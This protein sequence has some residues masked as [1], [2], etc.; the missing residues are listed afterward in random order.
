MPLNPPKQSTP[1]PIRIAVSFIS[2][3]PLQRTS[4]ATVPSHMHS[5]SPLRPA[6][7]F[8]D[9]HPARHPLGNDGSSSGG[10]DVCVA[11]R[12]RKG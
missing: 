1:D 10:S 8:R 11:R 2:E 7:A 5:A 12:K 9:S 4:A 3:T 6:M